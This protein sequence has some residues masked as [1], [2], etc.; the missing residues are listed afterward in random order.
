ML[1]KF[2]KDLDKD[3][4]EIIEEYE[5]KGKLHPDFLPFLTYDL[6]QTG[7][8]WPNKGEM[9]PRAYGGTDSQGRLLPGNGE[10]VKVPDVLKIIEQYKNQK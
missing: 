3:D 10:W 1:I 7:Y 6:E 9:I 8:P 5:K 2:D 4:L